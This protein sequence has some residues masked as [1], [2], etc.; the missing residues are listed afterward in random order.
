MLLG[1]HMNDIDQALRGRQIDASKGRQAAPGSSEVRVDKIRSDKIDTKQ[2][3]S[4]QIRAAKV[5]VVEFCAP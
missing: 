5:G 2:I 1:P 3:R 4:A